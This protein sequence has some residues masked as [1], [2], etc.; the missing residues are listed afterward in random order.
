MDALFEHDTLVITHQAYLNASAS[1]G[2][3][4]ERVAL[5]M[6]KRLIDAYA[7]ASQGGGGFTRGI[8]PDGVNERDT[9]ALVD[10][11]PLRKALKAVAFD[12]IGALVEDTNTRL[13]IG[14]KVDE[15]LKQ[16]QALYDQWAYCAKS[17]N[18]RLRII[19]L[20]R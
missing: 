2:D 19:G 4:W 3:R 7:R 6:L 12:Q 17:G 5:R 1:H 16:A 11:H 20:R 15:T 8:W 14:R 13:R 9:A 10:F 18:A